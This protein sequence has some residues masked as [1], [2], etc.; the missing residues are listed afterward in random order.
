[1]KIDVMKQTMITI[2]SGIYSAIEHSCHYLL[3][4]GKNNDKILE[5]LY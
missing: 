5:I 1:M 4:F 2:S 3:L